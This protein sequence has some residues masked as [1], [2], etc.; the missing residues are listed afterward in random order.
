MGSSLGCQIWVCSLINKSATSLRAN[1]IWMGAGT[2]IQAFGL[3]LILALLSKLGSVEFLGRYSLALAIT[4]PIFM[5]TALRLRDVQATDAQE[6]YRFGDFFGLRLLSTAIALGFIVLFLV[7]GSYKSS[8]ITIII[9]IALAKAVESISDILHGFLQKMERLDL[10]S[11][12]LIIRTILSV[13]AVAIGLSISGSLEFSLMGMMIIWVVILIM[14]DVPFV[15]AIHKNNSVTVR[16]FLKPLFRRSI[17]MAL[18]RAGVPLGTAT[19]LISLR[20]NIPRYALDGYWT[21][22]EIGIYSGMAYIQVA[23]TQIIH[24]LGRTVQPRLSIY[25]SANNSTEFKKL[26]VRLLVLVLAVSLISV[27]F[28]LT[29]GRPL[30]RILYTRLFANYHIE[31]VW[32]MV[33][34]G[35]INIGFLFMHAL[36][37]MQHFR[38]QLIIFGVVTTVTAIASFLFVPSL[39]ILGAALTLVVSGGM[40][41]IMT[42][43]IL[44]SKYHQQRG[45]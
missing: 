22:T 35:L 2:I 42:G 26:Y 11:K 29:F 32:I 28:S 15:R 38:V 43:A 1:F 3:W 17:I 13:L 25:F 9:I 34:A 33:A 14:V 31:F 20:A 8:T 19:L 39:G 4:A 6:Q 16:Y 10:V 45:V 37:A 27:L 7:F 44:F 18:L 24:A 30:L 41:M 36:L 5:F 12:S 21:E 40:Q 23:S